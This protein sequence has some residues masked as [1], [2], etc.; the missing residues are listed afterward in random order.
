MVQGGRWG[1]VVRQGGGHFNPAAALAREEREGA[2]D[3]PLISREGQL[4]AEPLE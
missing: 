1:G 4:E 3:L 2:L